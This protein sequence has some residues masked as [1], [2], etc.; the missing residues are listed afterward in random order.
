[1]PSPARNGACP[2]NQATRKE[3]V[4]SARANCGDSAQCTTEIS[5]FGTECGAFVHS[6]SNWSMVAREDIRQAREAALGECRKRGKNCSII[7]AVCAD[8]ADRYIAGN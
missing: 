6:G 4:A 2:G 3:A 7:A 5:F 8:G 1:M